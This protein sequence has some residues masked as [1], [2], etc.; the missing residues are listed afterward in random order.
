M[1]RKKV[2]PPDR[3]IRLAMEQLRIQDEVDEKVAL[4]ED[5]KRRLREISEHLLPNAMEEAGLGN[6]RTADGKVEIR[7]KSE[8]FAHF[9]DAKEGAVVSWLRSIGEG[10]MVRNVL[11]V[12]LGPGKDN[13]AV[14]LETQAKEMGLDCS[15]KE[16][17][18]TTSLK[19]FVRK[20]LEDGEEV[21]M[22]DIGATRV[23]KTTVKR[24]ES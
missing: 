23:I 1:A 20:R 22:R 3:V 13:A 10:G 15:R 19:A 12:E 9:S 7:L 8:V 18:N 6:I 17:V 16:Y 2:E 14:Q 24:K 11:T 4:L 5:A 21:P